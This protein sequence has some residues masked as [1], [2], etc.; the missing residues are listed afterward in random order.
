M[1]IFLLTNQVR[2][3]MVDLQQIQ[4]LVAALSVRIAVRPLVS[5]IPVAFDELPRTLA[6]SDHL[7][8]IVVR[9]NIEN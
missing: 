2:K 3:S 4:N 1:R 9:L 8:T 5:V 6:I 7:P